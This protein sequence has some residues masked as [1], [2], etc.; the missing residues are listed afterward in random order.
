M[1]LIIHELEPIGAC[2]NTRPDALV[3]SLGNESQG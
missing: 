3:S 2:G 1:T